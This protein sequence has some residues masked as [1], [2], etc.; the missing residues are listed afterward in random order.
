MKPALD[1]WSNILPTNCGVICDGLRDA[2][3]NPG[4]SAILSSL[5]IAGP[6]LSLLSLVSN[7]PIFLKIADFPE[8]CVAFLKCME[9]DIPLL[10]TQ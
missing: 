9:I 5:K 4:K 6:S 1:L 3:Q 2:T 8:L 7:F 10:H